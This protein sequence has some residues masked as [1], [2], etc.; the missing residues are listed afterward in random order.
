MNP[1]RYSVI[2]PAYNAEKTLPRCLDSLL[3]Q[4]RQD[5]EILLISDG[6]TDKTD[7]IAA[8]YAGKIRFFRQPH[9]GVSAARN[10][11]IRRA[12]GEY[13]T[14]VD[15]DDFVSG[16]YFAALD[17][18]PDCDFLAFGAG[19]C[20]GADPIGRLLATRKIM[21][22]CTKRIRRS[23]LAETGLV[24]R[25]GQQVGED[26][27]FCTAC[28][29]AADRVLV[30]PAEIYRADLTNA[31]SLSRRYRPGLD[32][33]MAEAFAFAAALDGAAEYADLLDYLYVKQAAACIA[34][35]YKQKTPSFVRVRE[36][37]GKF[38]PP[39]GNVTG[40]RHRCIRWLLDHSCLLT[41]AGAY[42]LKGREFEQCRKRKC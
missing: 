27:C 4:A 16:D 30:S 35:E 7:A 24:F 8:G 17:R 20:A 38:R 23:F 15:S 10:L 6:S 19:D 26:F 3:A 42:L 5:V 25:Q 41:W 39:I 11:G 36:I 28:A 1:I 31:E 34:E 9:A 40:L 18:E 21:S 13:V 22:A 14:F 37:C 12:A 29:L 2:I 33:T 32:Q